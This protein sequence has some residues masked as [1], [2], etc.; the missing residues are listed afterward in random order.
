MATPPLQSPA[1]CWQDGQPY[2]PTYGDSYYSRHNGLAETRHVFLTHN[3]LAARWASH[4]HSRPFVIAET[5]FGTG[6]N[7]LATWA[8]WQDCA[9]PG[10]R[11]HV[12]STEAHPLNAADLRAAL[13]L[14]PELTPYA[15][16]LLAAWPPPSP[17]CHRL[18]FANGQLVL[19]LWLGDA[20][21]TFTALPDQ[22]GGVVDAWYLDGF[23]NGASQPSPSHFQHLHR[24]QRGAARA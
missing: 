6:L 20:C 8:L 4:P 13:A 23:A 7:F 19:D 1:L 22:L 12:I 16:A 3:H 21:D 15:A 11:L 24:R 18:L 2:S 10:L 9:P 17:A 5:G 14:W